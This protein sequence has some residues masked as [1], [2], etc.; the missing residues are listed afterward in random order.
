ME[1]VS[2]MKD[3]R[4]TYECLVNRNLT[5]LKPYRSRQLKLKARKAA[6]KREDGAWRS[7]VPV[8]YHK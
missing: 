8:L 5:N 3:R 2:K 6:K 7:Q 1:K 4:S